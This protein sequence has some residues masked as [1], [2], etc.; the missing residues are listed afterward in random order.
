MSSVST[1][2]SAPAPV[3]S[4]CVRDYILNARRFI[5]LVSFARSALLPSPHSACSPRTVFHLYPPSCCP[6]QAMLYHIARQ[7][8][9]VPLFKSPKHYHII[10]A[11]PCHLSPRQRVALH[12]ESP[13]STTALYHTTQPCHHTPSSAHPPFARRKRSTLYCCITK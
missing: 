1:L 9:Q 10:S 6:W 4:R 12:F 8:Q 11:Q 5:A 3:L 7:Q 13:V 2:L